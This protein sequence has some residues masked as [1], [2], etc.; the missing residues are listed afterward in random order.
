MNYAKKK[1]INNFLKLI[2]SLGLIL[3][4]LNQVDLA[5]TI[6]LLQG[7]DLIFIIMALVV[8]AAQGFIATARW[9]L[10][11][12][13]QKVDMRYK[14]T[15]QILWAG[16]F[17][18]QSMPSSIGGDIVRG[19]YLKSRGMTISRATLRVLL[20]RLFGMAGLVVLV[21]FSLMLFVQL[22][23][24]PIARGG[25]FLIAGGGSFCILVLFFSDH[26]PGNFS[27]LRVI[28][29]FYSLS[30]EGRSCITNRHNGL[31]ILFYSIL[32]HLFSIIA[33]I[34]IVEGLG[35][36]LSWSGIMLI[37]PF[38]TLLMVIPISI[39]GWGVREGGMIVGLGY[40]GVVPEEALVLSILYGFSTL[41]IALPGGIGW[42][43]HRY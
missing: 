20:D 23:N 16:L 9:W 12:K 36:N 14:D 30:K 1:Y 11:L 29:G 7:A 41:L 40:L 5:D 3:F 38:I 34:L 39:A 33:V 26:L 2:I 15:L 21:L 24:D 22:V 13:H 42:L 35:I 27:H 43:I 17:F 18:S 31:T 8:L 19:Y 25:M 4:L 10:I 37:I 32:V 28:K 6:R